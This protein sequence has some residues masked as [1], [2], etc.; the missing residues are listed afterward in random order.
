MYVDPYVLTYVHSNFVSYLLLFFF[1]S[2]EN[3]HEYE[4]N[5]IPN[6]LSGVWHCCM[7]SFEAVLDDQ[8]QYFHT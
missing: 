6:L 4:V 7:P 5:P 1:E 3:L 8:I 2:W